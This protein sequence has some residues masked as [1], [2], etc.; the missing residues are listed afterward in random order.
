MST[1]NNNKLLKILCLHGYRQNGDVF[2]QKL[3]GLRKALK[4]HAELHFITAPNKI[5]VADSSSANEETESS[6]QYG[7]WFSSEDMT[8]DSKKPSDVCLGF[9]SSLK[10]IEETCEEKGPFD[11]FLGFSQGAAFVGV[12]CG[13]Q[14]MNWLK[15]EFRFAILVA[16]FKSL[17]HPHLNYYFK[18]ASVPSL[19][20]IG[21]TDN[22][23]TKERSELLVKQ[24]EHA[25][26][27]THPGGHF[28][29]ASALQRAGYIRFLEQRQQEQERQQKQVRVGSYVLE[30]V[31]DAAEVPT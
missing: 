5:P 25:E 16:G 14:E 18:E 4:K 30:Q 24:F 1:P 3:G 9:E 26:V 10:L 28:V 27:L 8:F 23:I 7:W 15:Y 29:P 20:V 2:R 13:M 22:M 17:C 19:H 11:G 21:E 31:E 12:L 6:D